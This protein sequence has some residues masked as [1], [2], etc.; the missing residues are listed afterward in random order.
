MEAVPGYLR[1]KGKNQLKRAESQT[2][3]HT[4]TPALGR[5]KQEECSEFQVVSVRPVK[6]HPVS[7]EKIAQAFG[8]RAK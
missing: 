6:K 7:A 5:Q 1:Q 3:W 8:D 4:P 2:Q